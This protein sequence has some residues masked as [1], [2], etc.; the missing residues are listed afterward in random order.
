MAWADGDGS[1]LHIFIPMLASMSG[2]VATVCKEVFCFRGREFCRS[3]VGVFTA[4]YGRR[5]GAILGP[6]KVVFISMGC[7]DLVKGDS[8]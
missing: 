1:F 8:G 6:C 4:Q 2:V 7:T 3:A 5:V